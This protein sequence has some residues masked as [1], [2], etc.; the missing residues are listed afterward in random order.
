MRRLIVLAFVTVPL[1]SLALAP[2]MRAQSADRVRVTDDMLR[3]PATGDWLR[4]RR[5]HTASGYSPLD[6]ITSRNVQDLRLAWSW[7]MAPGAQEQ[8]PLV[9]AGVMYLPHADG[10]VQALDARTGDR[11]WEFR[12]PA[13]EG[14]PDGD[15]LRN[16]ALYGDRLFVATKDAHLVALD[17]R[18]GRPVWQQRVGDP[19]DRVTYSAGPIVGDGR[20]FSGLTCGV[21]TS[22]SCVL[23]AHDAATGRELWRRA[24]VAGPADPPEHNA[25]WGGVPYAQ[26][27]K[28][29][30]WL[31]GS[32][33][34]DLKLLYWTTASPYPYPEILRGTGS[35]ALL[36]TNAILALDAATGA[37][38]WHFQMQ[39]RDNFD[40][41]HQDNPIL[42]DVTVN[43]VPRKAVYV[44]GK[45]G[46]LWAFDRE[47]GRYL[48]H[49]Q[50]VPYQNLYQRIDPETGAI[51][52]NEAIIPTEVGA[53]QVVC[54]GMRG[55]KL[56]QTKA[57]SPQTQ[58]LY[59][60]VS[61]ACTD[62]EVVPLSVS[63]SGLRYERMTHMDGAQEQVGRLVATSAA[64]GR[65]LWTYNQRAALGSV[66]ATAGRLV[67]VGDLHRYFRALE[68]DTGRVVWE[69]PL[70]GP[71]TGYPISYA[72]EGRQY[73]AV[74]VGGGTAGQRGM[75][76]LYPELA[77][78][79]GSNV[80]MVFSLSGSSVAAR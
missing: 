5:D 41:D 51:T 37:I 15:P 19:D 56:F 66:L 14:M 67:F 65:T 17:A 47:T 7:G 48:W 39:P 18:T 1:L 23:V 16:I 54:P 3:R 73:V 62:F 25:T 60:P 50:Q 31:A 27:R 70:S 68:A 34:P 43:G 32:Y 24:S 12:R 74:A 45:P 59:S 28:A 26:R 40:M 6:Q 53:R 9:H 46:V 20:V 76:Q 10:V 75:A 35:G 2:A 63:R 61:S 69:Q 49:A 77:S 71:V 44:L 38:R 78:S 55:G 30:F 58:A 36:Y 13:P 42:A 33:D 57:Y 11:I 80:L 79:S 29:S 21:G 72:V 52:M 22:Q 4:W 64:T 8:E